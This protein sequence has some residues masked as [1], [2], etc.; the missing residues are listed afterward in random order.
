MVNVNMVNPL[1]KSYRKIHFIICGL[2][3]L[4]GAPNT[5]AADSRREGNLNDTAQLVQ[6]EDQQTQIERYQNRRKNIRREIEKSRQEVETFTRKE[7]DIIKRLEQVELDLDK[8]RKRVAALSRELERLDDEISNASAASEALRKRIKVNEDY[9]AKR[10]VAVYK[11][12]WLG[13]IHLLASAE[14]MHEFIQRKA[15]LEHILAHDEKIRSELVKNQ[16]ELETVLNRLEA[17]KAQ[18]SELVAEHAGQIKQMAQER[19][20]RKSL[21]SDIRSQKALELAAIDALTQSANELDSKIQSLTTKM[22]GDQPDNN[23]PQKNFS[24]YKGLLIKPVEGRII[25]LFGPYKNPTY[26]ITNFRSGID[27]KAE[28]GE[29]I[30]SVFAGKVIYSN[31]F[32]GYGNMIIIDHGNNSYTVYAHLE[33]TFKT[34]GDG[35]ETGE[36]IATAGDTGSMVGTKLYFEVRH[37]GKPVDPLSWLKKG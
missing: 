20:T 1:E 36:V 29:P 12:N 8:S 11:M 3:L 28:K 34:K 15:A 21:L 10:L 13:K 2:L 7:S 19:A 32:K 23:F 6:L 25:S 9:V 26:N 4:W 31:W 33:E 24:D 5:H 14:T 30:R 35:V 17:H 16:A 18:K 27:I 37:H 22:T